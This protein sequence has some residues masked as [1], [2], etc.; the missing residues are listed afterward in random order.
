MLIGLMERHVEI[1]NVEMLSPFG[2]RSIEV[3]HHVAIYMIASRGRTDQR[4]QEFDGA[5]QLAKSPSLLSKRIAMMNKNAMQAGGPLLRRCR[6]SCSS[7]LA[8]ISSSSC[9]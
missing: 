4:N 2:L 7:L 9:L 5:M 1:S 8:P 6:P 3:N